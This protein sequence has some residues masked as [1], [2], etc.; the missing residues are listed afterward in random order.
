MQ[1]IVQVCSITC[2]CSMPY[3][4]LKSPAPVICSLY[5][6]GIQLSGDKGRESCWEMEELHCCWGEVTLCNPSHMIYPDRCKRGLQIKVESCIFFWTLGAFGSCVG[7]QWMTC[8][9]YN[10]PQCWLKVHGGITHTVE[11]A[12]IRVLWQFHGHPMK[13]FINTPFRRNG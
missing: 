5:G 11:S 3:S 7:W 8:L 1:W 10:Q 12:I 2:T 4:C 6:S 9:S 13:I